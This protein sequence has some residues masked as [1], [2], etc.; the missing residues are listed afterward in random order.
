MITNM[1]PD[2]DHNDEFV[3]N[4]TARAFAVVSSYF[5]WLLYKLNQIGIVVLHKHIHHSYNYYNI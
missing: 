2:I 1:R 5:C 3:R 4:V